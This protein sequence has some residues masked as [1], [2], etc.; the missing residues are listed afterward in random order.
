LLC[1]GD[2]EDDVRRRIEHDLDLRE[3]QRTNARAADEDD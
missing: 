3:A 2:L 1:S